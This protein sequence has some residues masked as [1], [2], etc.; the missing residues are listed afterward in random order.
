MNFIDTHF[1]LDLWESTTEIV[2]NIE[3]HEIYTIAVTNTPSVF[4]YTYRAVLNRKYV[5]AALGLHPELI[6]ERHGELPEF[7]RLFDKTRYIGEVG[8]DY[9]NNDVDNHKLQRKIFS[10]IVELCRLNKGKILTVHSR[11]AEKD[12]IEIIGSDFPGRVILHWYSGSLRELN[13]AVKSGFFFSVNSAMCKSNAGRKIIE[14]IP[15]DRLLTESDGPFVK[16][17]LIPC[18]PMSISQ[19]VDALSELKGITSE[20]MKRQVYLNMHK[21]LT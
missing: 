14:N 11:R 21:L 9:S 1:H 3:N 16:D 5:K 19:I 10:K 2:S 18:S 8:L 20:Q 15:L 12:V 6:S 7:E 17:Q 4:D 13:Q